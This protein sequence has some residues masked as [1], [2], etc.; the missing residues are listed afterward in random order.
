MDMKKMAADK[1][2]PEIFIP[3]GFHKPGLYR[4][5]VQVKRAG[6]IQTAVFD[7]AVQ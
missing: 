1:I 4:I 7:A 5:F 2:A 6:E 3:Y